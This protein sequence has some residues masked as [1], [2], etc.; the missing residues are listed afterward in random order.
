MATDCLEKDKEWLFTFYDFP[1]QHGGFL[2]W[3]TPC[4]T[5]S[6]E[7]FLL[8]PLVV[9]LP[10]QLFKIA[11]FTAVAFELSAFFFLLT[12]RT[13]LRVWLLLAAIFHITNTLLLN[14]PFYTHLP[15]YLSF[16]ALARF[17]GR[18]ET[19]GRTT[20]ALS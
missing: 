20:R 4:I 13:A 12:G 8:A 16:V 17:S 10:P 19:G 15:V 9:K 1:A 11:D 6:V 14:I 18:P 7:T 3:F 5:R 2:S